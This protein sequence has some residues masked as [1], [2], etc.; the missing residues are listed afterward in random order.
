M[1]LVVFEIDCPPIASYTASEVIG[2][3]DPDCG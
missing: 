1:T 3:F 2:L